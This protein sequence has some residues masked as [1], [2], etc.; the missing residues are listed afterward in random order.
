MVVSQW[1]VVSGSLSVV[2]SH[3]LCALCFVLCALCFVLCA[4]CFVF[5][6]LRAFVLSGLLVFRFCRASGFCFLRSE[7]SDLRSSPRL[8]G[9]KQ[10]S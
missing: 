2:S 8:F 5:L 3:M 1:S 7:I 10:K 9:Q 4:L 6:L